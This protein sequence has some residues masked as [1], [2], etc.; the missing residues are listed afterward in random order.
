MATELTTAAFKEKVFDYT[1]NNEWNYTGDLPAII[2]FWAPWCGP[3]RA[4]AP[5]FEELSKEFA[6]KVHFYKLNTDDEQEVA[7]AF[8]IRSIPSILFIPVGDTPK[9]MVGALPIEPFRQAIEE[10][11]L[12]VK[13][14][15]TDAE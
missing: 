7:S 12:G 4:V 2:D 3:C 13:A 14:S 11:L 10:E 6:G 9:M 15:E 8:G 1:T 5:V